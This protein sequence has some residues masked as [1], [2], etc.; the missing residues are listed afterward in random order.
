MTS[1]AIETEL[2]KDLALAQDAEDRIAITRAELALCDFYERQGCPSPHAALLASL[3]INPAALA[4]VRAILPKPGIFE[5]AQ[6]RRLYAAMLRYPCGG[7]LAQ[8]WRVLAEASELPL[9][10]VLVYMDYDFYNCHQCEVYALLL[11]LDAARRRVFTFAQRLL[12]QFNEGQPIAAID[13][14]L[15][16]L[17]ALRQRL[18]EVA[19]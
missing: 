17:T 10:V 15:R 1:K 12:R 5:D 6:D 14:A 8:W 7:E 18:V 9:A 19:Q 3:L 16:D 13:A 11:L 4:R 2:L